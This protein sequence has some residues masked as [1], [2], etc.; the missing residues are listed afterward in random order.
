[1]REIK[2]R[3][4]DKANNE[5]FIVRTLEWDR[6]IKPALPSNVTA[7]MQFTGLRD[8][9]GKEIF[10]GDIVLVNEAL[11]YTVEWKDSLAGWYPFS[12]PAEGGY[13]WD[14]VDLKYEKVEIIGNVHEH[15]HLL[16][17]PEKESQ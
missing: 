12:A 16:A 9:N 13:E 4:W 15:P 11:K 7:I 1:M 17:S 3:A 6:T 10:E 2:F 14:N 8:K 5:M